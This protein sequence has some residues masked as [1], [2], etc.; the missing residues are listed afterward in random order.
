MPEQI[1]CVCAIAVLGENGTEIIP[2]VQRGS[3]PV[4]QDDRGT[5]PGTDIVRRR[6]D[7]DIFYE[8]FHQLLLTI[9]Y[10]TLNEVT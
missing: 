9:N 4:D 5:C 7:G 10:V 3:Q 1:D 8:F 2:I 6:R